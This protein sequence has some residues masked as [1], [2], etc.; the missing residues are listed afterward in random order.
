VFYPYVFA[1]IA[2]AEETI[3]PSISQIQAVIYGSQGDLKIYPEAIEIRYSISINIAQSY[4]P[5]YSPP[6]PM[7][8]IQWIYPNPLPRY[9]EIRGIGVASISYLS[10]YSYSTP[11][12]NNTYPEK[13]KTT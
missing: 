10:S 1:L 9:A 7:V 11:A 8:D 5:G 2:N 3:E 12:E 6:P 13:R 4:Q